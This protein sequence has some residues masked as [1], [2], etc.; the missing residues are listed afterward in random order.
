MQTFK[1]IELNF[2]K[3]LANRYTKIILASILASIGVC[4]AAYTYLTT[5]VRSHGDYKL[6]GAIFFCVG[7]F[8]ICFL[9]W[10]LFTGKIGYA[11]SKKSKQ[12]LLDISII[13]LTNVIFCVMFGLLMKFT[14]NPLLEFNGVEGMEKILEQ[15]Q[16][17]LDKN[18]IKLIVEEAVDVQTRTYSIIAYKIAKGPLLIPSGFFCGFSIHVVVVIWRKYSNVLIR[19]VSLLFTITA[20]VL[21]GYDHFLANTFMITLGTSME[22]A[23]EIGIDK[24]TLVVLYTLIGNALGA[25]F[26]EH[27]S[28]YLDQ[29]H[30]NSKQ[31]QT[32]A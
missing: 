21:S 23:R 19:V 8:L 29:K 18:Q 7:F 11:V 24:L 31:E 4:L 13:F 17:L 27:A 32:Q 30:P 2:Q 28:N 3:F 14:F 22:K 10:Y 1:K 12:Y 16:P 26:I 9:D 25:L 15:T 6:F 20:F 5:T